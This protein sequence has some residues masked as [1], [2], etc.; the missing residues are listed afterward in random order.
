MI[1]AT[2]YDNVSKSVKTE[3]EPS[4]KCLLYCLLSAGHCHYILVSFFFSSVRY[5]K[6]GPGFM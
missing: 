5:E 1:K 3:H 4:H 6:H 2:S